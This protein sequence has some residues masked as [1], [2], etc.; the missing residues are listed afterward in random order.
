[1]KGFVTDQARTIGTV[2]FSIA[3]VTP[4][5]T[6]WVAISAFGYPNSLPM[7]VELR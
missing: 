2:F 1:L 6:A 3:S 7:C 4:S 5:L